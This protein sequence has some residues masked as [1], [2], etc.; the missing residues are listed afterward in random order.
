MPYPVVQIPRVEEVRRGA[1]ELAEGSIFKGGTWQSLHKWWARRD[2]PLPT[3]ELPAVDY[4]RAAEHHGRR[5][6]VAL[7]DATII[8]L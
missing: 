8:E 4:W 3:L 7:P 2:S 6:D 1:P 5:A